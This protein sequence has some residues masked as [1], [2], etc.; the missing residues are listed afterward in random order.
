MLT[1]ASWGGLFIHMSLYSSAEL[2]RNPV[3]TLTL[4]PFG[5]AI[6]TVLG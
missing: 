5:L 2:L 3:A 1:G 6:G 4:M